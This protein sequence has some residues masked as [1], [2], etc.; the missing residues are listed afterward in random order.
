MLQG[1]DWV[2]MA[3]PNAVRATEI[4]AQERFVIESGTLVFVPPVSDN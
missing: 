2:T 1:L 3:A 4:L